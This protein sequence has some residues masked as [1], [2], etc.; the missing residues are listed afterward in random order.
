MDNSI[1]ANIFKWRLKRSKIKRQIKLLFLRKKG[2]IIFF[3]VNYAEAS[4]NHGFSETA[5]SKSLSC[6]KMPSQVELLYSS[7]HAILTGRGIEQAI[8]LPSIPLYVAL[9]G[10]RIEQVITFPL[11][12]PIP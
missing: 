4:G 8:I 11:N 7:A 1:D 6:A 12:C 9:A 2:P 5:P 3:E 10:R